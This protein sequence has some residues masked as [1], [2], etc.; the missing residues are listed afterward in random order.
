MKS[1]FICLTFFALLGVALPASITL[2]RAQ[3][4]KPVS[5]CQSCEYVMK[6]IRFQT[7]DQAQPVN[8]VKEKLKAL[9]KI[10][11]SSFQNEE[12]LSN[13]DR[14]VQMIRNGMDSQSIC[15]LLSKCSMEQPELPRITGCN[16]C[17]AVVDLIKLEITLSNTTIQI[18]MKAVEELC[19][20][21]GDV[22]VYEECKLILNQ[23]KQIIEWLEEQLT[24]TDICIKLGFCNNTMATLTY[25]YVKTQLQHLLGKSSSTTLCDMCMMVVE[26]VDSK[27]EDFESNLENIE[28]ELND[29]CDALGE[30]LAQ[31]CKT[32]VEVVLNE[33]ETNVKNFEAKLDP[34]TTCKALYLCP[35]SLK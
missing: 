7:L 16:V 1:L 35:K 6:F 18:I 31:Q 30:D 10:F 26:M 19:A 17:M 9:F 33:I 22:P 24:P 27:L 32:I 15:Q 5:D 12:Y 4:V 8:A 29:V 21:L 14:Y 11:P 23:I 28:A 2:D 34:S 20:I 3:E 13:M 25:D